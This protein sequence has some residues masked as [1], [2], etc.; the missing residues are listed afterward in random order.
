MNG[1]FIINK[2][3]KI[4]MNVVENVTSEKQEGFS[5]SLQIIVD[6]LESQHVLTLCCH[7]QESL[8]CASCFY[9]FEK[10]TM[11]FLVMTDS[12]TRHGHLLSKNPNVAGT[13]SDQT[14]DIVLLKGIQFSGQM[15]LLIGDKEDLARR[16]FYDKYPVAKLIPSPIWR[17]KLDEIKMTD[18]TAGFANKFSWKR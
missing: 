13:I 2:L 16:S 11:S 12:K 4:T 17:V 15:A 10:E 14:L 8:W 5:D 6:Y 18:N 9:L 7:S 3:W 1:A